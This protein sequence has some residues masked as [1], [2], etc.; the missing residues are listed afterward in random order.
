M[1]DLI[2]AQGY[3]ANVGIVLMHEDGRVFLG[4]R[5]GGR[6]WQFPQ[7]GIQVGESPQQALYRELREEIGLAP[8]D[9]RL[10]GAT[11]GW[12][13]YRLPPHFMRRDRS[14]VCIGQKQR[15]FLLRP[16]RADLAFRFDQTSLP[17][18]DRWRWAEF[19]EPMREVI[20]FKR[21]VYGRA[22]HELGRIA[23]G[24]HLPPYPDWWSSV[25][26]GA[27]AAP[28]AGQR[29]RRSRRRRAPVRAAPRSGS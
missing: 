1:T 20:E 13:R 6:G 19:W 28:R 10:I 24:G 25:V 7:G 29:G 2:D 9:V 8:E 18:F 4:R 15:W 12:L 23:F 11:S 26:A 16:V 3:R 27:A 21:G 22:L 14:P 17:E 5:S